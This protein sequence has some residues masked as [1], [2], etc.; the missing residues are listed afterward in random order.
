MST[1]VVILAAGKGT[2]MG[3]E[4]PKPLVEVA[5]RPMIEHLLDSV[6]DSEID[7]SPVLV[8]SPEGVE[9]FNE[10]CRDKRCEFVVQEEQLGTGHATLTAR[11]A[12]N[13]TENIVVLYGD[14]PFI[15]SE[16]LASLNEMHADQGATI[17][18]L[19]TTVPNFKKEHTGFERWGRIIRDNVGRILE[20]KEAKDASED[21]LA[22]K[23]LNPAIYAFN[24]EWLWEHLPEVQNK[25]ANGE[26]YLTDLVA[27]AIEEGEEVI[28]S[29]AKPFEVVGI[30][31]QEELEY[32][33]K[34]FG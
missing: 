19:T 7:H 16:L 13:G 31:S 33:E 21:E 17:T 15:S 23:E 32:A 9:K 24:A 22:I 8:V 18:M 20:I 3:A 2:R 29:P 14:H 1:R 26:Y 5:G 30:N 10:V 34:I 6:H 25:N 4:I 27:I 28:T 11:E 12:M